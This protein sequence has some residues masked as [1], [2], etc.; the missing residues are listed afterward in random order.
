MSERDHFSVEPATTF[1]PFW[2]RFPDFFLYPMQT[3]SIIRIALCSV[4]GSFF[5]IIPNWVGDPFYGILLIV[6][7]K[8]ALTVTGRT[9]NGQFDE[10][11]GVDDSDAG[12]V[13]QT[14]KLLSLLGM[15]WMINTLTGK[16]SGEVGVGLGW[17]LSVIVT[18]ASVMIIVIHRSLIQA[19][20]PVRIIHC[21]KTIGAPY[22]SLC[23]ILLS[24]FSCGDWLQSFLTGHMHSWLV[25]PLSSFVVFYFILIASHLIGYVIYQYHEV[26]GAHAAVSFEKMEANTLPGSRNNQMLTRLSSLIADGHHE[27]ALELLRDELCVR[28]DNIDL[29]ER[30]QKLLSATGKHKLA[31][32]HAREF[33]AQLVAE[34]RFFQALDL[35]EQWLKL[36]PE[37]K[38]QDAYLLYDLASAAGVAKRPKLA[39][40]LLTDFDR[41][42]PGH[43]HIPS[44]YLLTAQLLSEHFQKNQQAIQI[45]HTLQT[46]FPDHQLAADA[47]QYMET[48]VRVAAIG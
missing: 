22:L 10:P 42:Y 40:D 12:D 48:L 18:P 13:T 43:P 7:L 25:F 15:M 32:N 21:I 6:F 34:K 37:F 30:Y 38:Q 19:L 44:V 33:I 4:F 29:N 45:L 27:T 16:T 28:G 8:Y 5:L 24:L 47:R 36:D 9:A 2:R 17:L 23:F 3:G 26:L 1:P 41:K 31:M 14:I 20:N 39:L 11:N 46:E 35:C